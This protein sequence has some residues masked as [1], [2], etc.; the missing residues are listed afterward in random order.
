M[1]IQASRSSDPTA[2]N[3]RSPRTT[4]ETASDADPIS[5]EEPQQRE[6]RCDVQRDD[7]REVER[8]FA[9]LLRRLGHERVPAPAEPCGNDHRVTKTRDGEQLGHALDERD[10]D[11]LE[12]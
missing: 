2:L 9:A 1:I 11:G 6:R 3:R 5:A 4:Q 8:G 10:D 7:E 12:I